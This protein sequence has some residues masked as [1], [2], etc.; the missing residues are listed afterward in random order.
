MKS[1]YIL[2][3]FILSASMLN[4][5]TINPGFENWTI[6][7]NTIN[8]AGQATV[9]GFTVDY[10][11]I[12]SQFDYNEAVSWSSLNQLTGTDSI[13]YPGT[14][15]SLVELVTESSD[16]VEGAKSVKLESKTIEI[17]AQV[18]ILG[19]WQSFSVENVA[20]GLIVSGEL[21]ID[22]NA[23]AD[24]LLNS[25]N[26]T[27]LNPFTYENTG[28]PIDFQ[29]ASLMGSY[30]Y[31][32][33]G[34]DSAMFV[35]G[36]IKD[37]VVVAY[38]IKRLPNAA[39]WTPFELEYEYLSCAMPDT[40]ITLFCSSN[41]DATFDNGNFSVNSSYTGENGSVLFV[42]DL[43]MDTL[44]VSI[45]PP[46]AF[47]DMSAIFDNE[48]ATSDV[49]ANDDFCGGLAPTPIILSN[50]SNGTA[51]VNVD[52]SLDY[53]PDVGFNGLDT[54]T[55]YV[56]NDSSLCDTANWY[57]T[58]TGIPLCLAVDDF[59]SL[60][61]NGS[62]VFDATANDDD[63]G[64]VPN[65]MISPF[66]GVANVESNGNISYSPLVGFSGVD[67]LTY[68]ICSPNNTSQCA[69]AKVYY[70]ITTGIK[71]IP[72]SDLSMVPNPANN[73]VKVSAKTAGP[74]RLS[75]FNLLG[76]ELYSTSFE[77]E[78]QLDLK[79]FVSGLY[80]VQFESNGA[81]ATKKLIVKK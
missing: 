5:Q 47:D 19:A 43:N 49:I 74:I 20:P 48:V 73:R 79:A 30:K 62:S 1:I 23:F 3:L 65:I 44:D 25:T 13:V 37:R 68:E 14:G 80:L 64:T 4:A 56:C 69:T 24:Q 45:F 53:T 70:E 35:S 42:D 8:V 15:N 77:I 63:C 67:S 11:L 57:I 54:V 16:F 61:T 66:S 55:Y 18:N 72:A 58:V 6:Q 51:A 29:P 46:L 52:D 76:K 36:L 78:T 75:V 59:R 33:A 2:G 60:N 38:V 71:E 12:N 10:E 50:G 41:L 32:G 81:V 21:D 17:I 26:L 40:I 39:T 9:Q 22:E 34:G 31:T 27:S 7:Q 28:S